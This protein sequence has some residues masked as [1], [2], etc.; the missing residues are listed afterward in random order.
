MLYITIFE[1]GIS[2]IRLNFQ[3][4]SPIA[5]CIL[6]RVQSFCQLFARLT[7]AIVINW[8]LMTKLLK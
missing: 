3:I 7:K 2:N 6:G 8:S 4:V 1:I 5:D